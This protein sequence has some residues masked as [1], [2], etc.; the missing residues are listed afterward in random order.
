MLN[1]KLESLPE[2]QRALW[3]NLAQVPGH[4]VLYGGTAIALRLGH[5]ASVDFDFFTGATVDANVLLQSLPALRGAKILQNVSQTLTVQI[6]TA[7]P[8]KLSFF[9]GLQLGRVGQPERT[10]DGVAW[11]AS[12]L[13]L[14]GTKAAVITQ[15]AESKDYVDIL[16]LVESGISLASAMAAASAIY[17]PQYT[18]A[19]T[20]KSL[21][22]FGDG[23]LPRLPSEL[24]TRLARLASQQSLTLPHISR[25]SD[26]VQPTPGPD[27]NG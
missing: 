27:E 25:V 20:L 23:D 21:T 1:P 22:H 11:V 2:A 13:D 19:L 12:S 18:P 24:K 17:G 5:R 16:A 4:F 26:W 9:G 15:R 8:V 14:A 10:S 6:G 3:P 7:D